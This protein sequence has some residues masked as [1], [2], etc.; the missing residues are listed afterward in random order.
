MTPNDI[1]LR[2]Y[3]DPV[4][5][6]NCQPVVAMPFWLPSKMMGIMAANNGA[7]LAAPQVGVSLRMFVT[8]WEEVFINPRIEECGGYDIIEEACLSLPGQRRYVGRKYWV[9][10]GGKRYIGTKARIIQHEMDHLDGKLI[11]D[12]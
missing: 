2:V 7:G 11:T 3:P 9:V 5:R 8:H 4:L 12:L 10:V 6:V 1:F